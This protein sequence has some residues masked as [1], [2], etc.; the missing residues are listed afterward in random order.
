MKR[1]LLIVG[2]VVGLLLVVAVAVP[3]FIDPNRFRPMLEEKLT[4]ALARQVKLGDLKLSILAG[5]VTASDL[6]IADNPAYSREPFVQA[7][8]LAVS[9]ELWPL[10]ASKKLHVTG[11]TLDHPSIALIQSPNGEWNFS[12]LGGSKPAAAK[13]TA[14]SSGDLDITAKLVKITGGRFSLGNT[15]AKSKPLVLE[16]VNVEVKDFSPESEFPFTLSTKIAG[17]GAVKLD[18]KAGPLDRADTASSPFS[19]NLN[20][21]QLD[22]VGTGLAQNAPAIAGLISLA[23]SCASDGKSARIKGKIK[24]E[25]LKLAKGGAPAKRAVEFDFAADHN[26]KKRSGRLAQGDI[27][28]GGAPARLTGTYA[29][30]GETTA[31]HMTLD[32]PK[33]P[34]PELEG[35][36]PAL[37]VSFPQGSSLQG[38][39][40][41]VKL[42]MEG[43]LDRLVTSG[44]VSLDNTKLAGFDMG[45]KLAMIER[46]AGIKGGPDTEIQTFA[47]G[48]RMGPEG[49]TAENIQ[50]IV[51][52]IG[53]LA[54]GGTVSLANALDFRM[55]AALHTGG[56][57]AA[58]K[59]A[60]IPFTVAGTASDPVFRPDVKAVVKEEAKKT[61]E[62]A[63]GGL[64]KGLLGGKK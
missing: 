20:I 13:T 16:D 29:A 7:K 50:L 43:V 1:L 18:G 32:A 34:I 2:G 23:G 56:M 17:G 33:M 36:L 6:S 54:G 59:D 44:S 39:T 45:R 30:E 5:A 8:S 26:L 31:L 11:L 48:I 46:F 52:S 28:I 9:V 41:S 64:L 38:G 19:V 10:I 27:H 53:T 62:N 63:A 24:G 37:A 49:M 25:K 58:M 22:L 47:S 42:V 15:G 51:P 21:D 60:P 14:S 4:Q 35:M 3:F 61:L 40:A 57:M 12:N 55:T